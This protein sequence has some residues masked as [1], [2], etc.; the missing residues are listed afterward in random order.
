MHNFTIGWKIKEIGAKN[1]SIFCTPFIMIIW[2]KNFD[3]F[4]KHKNLRQFSGNVWKIDF[5]IFKINCEV[6]KTIFQTWKSCHSKLLFFSK[7]R[8]FIF[9][10][11]LISRKESEFSSIR[12]YFLTLFDP[13]YVQN[14]SGFLLAKIPKDNL[15]HLE[16]MK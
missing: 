8:I 15:T 7:I 16:E 11:L 14:Y 4:P 9:Q 3:F 1:R 10:T 6:L 2:L 5:Q 13:K 12:N